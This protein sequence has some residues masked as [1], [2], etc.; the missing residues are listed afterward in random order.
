M[1][2]ALLL[3]DQNEFDGL[4]EAWAD[5]RL[6]SLRA[7]ALFAG[8]SCRVEILDEGGK[9]AVNQ[10]VKGTGFNGPL[11]DLLLRLLT[12]LPSASARNRPRRSWRR[13]RTGSTPTTRSPTAGP[14]RP[15]TSACPAPTGP[16]THLWI[17]L[18]NY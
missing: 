3:E 16:G 15:T 8:P 11:R 9:V 12:G 6:L 13:S 17:A 18:K 5:G 1:A 10:L 2:Q 7:E 4:T 14:S